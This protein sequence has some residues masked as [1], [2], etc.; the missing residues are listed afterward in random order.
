MRRSSSDERR[1]TRVAFCIVFA[2]AVLLNSPWEFGQPL[3]Y[4]GVQVPGALWHCSYRRSVTGDGGHDLC[5][6]GS[7][8]PLGRLGTWHPRGR[9]IWS[10]RRPVS[11]WPWRWNRVHLAERSRYSALMPVVPGIGA[12]AVPLAQMR[13]LPPV[14]FVLAR[15]LLT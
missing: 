8:F 4:E 13:A 6:G 15:R 3:F 7:V 11:S 2:L 9:N 1:G 14:V 10:L 5:R 12:R